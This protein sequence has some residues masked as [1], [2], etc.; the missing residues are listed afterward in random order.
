MLKPRLETSALFASNKT[1]RRNNRKQWATPNYVGFAWGHHGLPLWSKLFGIQMLTS[2]FSRW[3]TGPLSN[4]NTNL[5][6]Q[7]HRQYNKE[8]EKLI[9]DYLKKVGKSE[10]KELS[11]EEIRQLA[12]KIASSESPG[13]RAFFQRLGASERPP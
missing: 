2:F 8:V 6:D 3:R 11:K 9:E 1:A 12:E 4:P 7:L 5:Y 10:I 13:I